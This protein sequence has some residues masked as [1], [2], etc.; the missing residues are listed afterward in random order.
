MKLKLDLH[1]HSSLSHD[2]RMSVQEL[3]YS[4]Q[5]AGLDG[6]AVCDHDVLFRADGYVPPE[7]FLLIYGEEFSTEYGHVLGLFLTQ[8]IA[9]RS[10][11]EIVREIRAQGGLC[12]L[13]HP[14]ERCTDPE[15]FAPLANMLDGVEVKNGR[16][17]RKNRRA[18]EM[19]AE[20]AAANGLP[21]FAGSDAHV[22]REV[23]NCFVTVDVEE[24]TPEAVK[25]ALLCPGNV[26]SGQNGRQIDV[27][28]SQWTKLNKQHGGILKRV[29]WAAFAVKCALGDLF[30][31]EE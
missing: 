8:P 11:P 6:A 29:K 12:V 16:A 3:V 5:A 15:R 9:A 17:N 21:F 1:I 18:N 26:V 4:A 27:A 19:A 10:F 14:F 2:G 23:G 30:R 24:R 22:P 25:N 7:G 31:R 28:R 13:A 20:F